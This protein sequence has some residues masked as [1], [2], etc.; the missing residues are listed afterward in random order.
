MRHLITEHLDIWTAAHKT[1]SSAGRGSS[2]KLDLYG[3]KKLREL[4]LELA[5]RGKLV[6]QDPNDEPVE[7]LLANL[8]SKKAAVLNQRHVSY[9]D[10]SEDPDIADMKYPIP[11]SWL[12][13]RFCDAVFFQ[14]GPGIRNWQFKSE[15][16]KLLN[17]SNIL[18][19]DQLNFD[20]SDKFVA[21]DEFEQK[22]KHFE[23]TDGD[24]LF[25]GSGASWGKVAWFNNPGFRVM[26]N[27]ST[28][29]MSFFDPNFSP[30]YLYYFV[31]SPNFK[32]QLTS[33][34]VGLQPNFGSTHL[35][36]AYIALPPIEEQHRIVAKVDELMAFCDQ[37]EQ[38]QSDNI[39]AHAQLV[40]ALLATL[41]NSSDHNELQNNWQRIAAHFDT[42]FTTEHS[43]DQ[44]KQTILQLAVMGKLVPQNPNDEPASEL[45]KKIAAEKAQLIKEGKIKK[46]KPLPE[47]TDEEKPFE[48]PRGWECVRLGKIATI[49]GGKRLPNGHSFSAEKT[50]HV[51][52][53]VT[54][55][56]NGTI[57]DEGLV[58][59]RPETHS[60]ISQYVIS[61]NDLYITIAGT[62]GAVGVVPQQL[63]GMNLTENAAKIIFRGVEKYWLQK[64]LSSSYIQDQFT[65]KTNQLAQPKLAL[66]RI[67]SSIVFLP[68]LAE[69]H[70]IVTKVDELMALC[71]TLKINLQNAQAT[72]LALADALVEQ[73][74][75]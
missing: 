41:T 64:T 66:H 59:I 55:M 43:I 61:S 33:Q 10:I 46:E 26:L 47:I 40:E 7:N 72:Q 74:V 17:V 52:I 8:N 5:V 39:A 15:G 70:R 37:L 44:L 32:N 31:K 34:L 24:L 51:Y 6:P 20:N 4:I 57:N 11:D 38:T 13:V 23:L 73:A 30:N 25:A 63:D 2:N 3:I 18:F 53:R 21:E 68:P 42:L 60:L 14:E 56:K 62:I 67:E 50:S 45:L 75:G 49:K 48:L 27:T 69:Q 36:R 65:E 35:S 1:R 58:Y 71:D 9:R 16:I 22:Y 28:M 29:R 19:S 54:D 12:W